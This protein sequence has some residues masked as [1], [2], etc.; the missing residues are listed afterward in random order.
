MMAPETMGNVM[1]VA[2]ATPCRRHLRLPAAKTF[3]YPD[4]LSMALTMSDVVPSSSKDF[5]CLTFFFFPLEMSR[6]LGEYKMWGI[7]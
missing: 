2:E 6:S 5:A 1:A 3:H 4:S 7:E